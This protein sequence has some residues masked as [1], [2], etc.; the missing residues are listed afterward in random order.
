[1]LVEYLMSYG[2]AKIIL[3]G[4]CG[5]LV[6]IPEGELIIPISALRD[7]GVSYHYLPPSRE[8]EIDR[9]VVSL[10]KETLSKKA[11]SFIESK[12]WST[13]G[14]FR[15]SRDMINYRRE[16]GCT[17]VEMECAAMAAVAKFRRGKFGAILYA[18]DTLAD[19]DHYDEREW[20]NNEIARKASFSLSLEASVKLVTL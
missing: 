3:N 20:V 1:M 15:E 7:E 13:D 11:V 6:D 17:T 9:D 19:F 10:I 5:V 2:V 14:F 18:G 16:E 8:I 12:V 4:G